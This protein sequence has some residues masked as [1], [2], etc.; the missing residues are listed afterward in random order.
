MLSLKRCTVSL[1]AGAKEVFSAIFFLLSLRIWGSLVIKGVKEVFSATSKVE[2]RE[3]TIPD[4]KSVGEMYW[5]LS[6]SCFA[7]K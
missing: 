7:F 6:K 2:G 3:F 1:I 4:D 5:K